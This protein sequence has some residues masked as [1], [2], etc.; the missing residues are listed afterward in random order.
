MASKL[1]NQTARTLGGRCQSS[2]E[3]GARQCCL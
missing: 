2:G 3:C 1:E